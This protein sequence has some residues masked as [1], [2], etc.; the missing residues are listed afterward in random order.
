MLSG[1]DLLAAFGGALMLEGLL[2]VFFPALWRQVYLKFISLGEWQLRGI[3]WGILLAAVV[4]TLLGKG[5]LGMNE[6]AGAGF[7]T[8]LVYSMA[9]AAMIEGGFAFL[10]AI[11]PDFRRFAGTLAGIPAA[12]IREAGI[13]VEICGL[14]LLALALQ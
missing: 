9:I 13:M 3:A 12:R 7:G 8:V 5:L 10:A 1:E 2:P 11:I 6:E 14:L 4:L